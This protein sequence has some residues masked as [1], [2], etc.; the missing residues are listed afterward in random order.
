MALDRDLCLADLAQSGGELVEQRAAPT[1][2]QRRA[3]RIEQ[4]DLGDRE[5]ETVLAARRGDLSAE[6]LLD[7]IRDAIF[8]ARRLGQRQRLVVRE[9]GRHGIV[10]YEIRRRRDCGGSRSGAT[11]FCSGADSA[12]GFGAAAGSKSGAR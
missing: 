12:T 11:A 6:A 9:R 5:L 10:R 7:Q 1:R 3:R 8:A 4:R 2:V